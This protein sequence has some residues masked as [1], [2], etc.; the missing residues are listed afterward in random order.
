MVAIDAGTEATTPTFKCIDMFA[1]DTWSAEWQEIDNCLEKNL[2]DGRLALLVGSAVSQYA[3]SSVPMGGEISRACTERLASAIPDKRL[4]NRVRL[5]FNRMPFEVFMARLGELDSRMA[6]DL[7]CRL[8]T[9]CAPNPLHLQLATLMAR[10]LTKAVTL[11]LITTN[12]D[13]GIELAVEQL[14]KQ[15][16]WPSAN[17]PRVILHRED[18]SGPMSPHEI[19][20]IHGMTA[21]PASLVLDYKSEFRLD[22]WKLDHL[23][24]LLQNKVLLVVGFSGM[25]L[26]VSKAVARC[27]IDRVIWIRGD[28][29]ESWTLDAS[30]VMRAARAACAVGVKWRLEQAL[31][32]LACPARVKV[33]K[34]AIDA[35]CEQVFA[36]FEEERWKVWARWAGLRAGHARLAEGL[37]TQEL[38]LL[39]PMHRLE[40]ESFGYY[41]R[42]RHLQG[43]KL[44]RRAAREARASAEE[45]LYYRNTEAEYLNRGAYSFRAILAVFSASCVYWVKWRRKQRA[46]EYNNLRWSLVFA[47]PLFPIWLN[48]GFIQR[49]TRV[50]LDYISRSVQQADLDKYLTI[51]ALMAEPDSPDFAR[52]EAQYQWLGQP[53]RLVNLYRVMAL[54][55]LKRAIRNRD[56]RLLR[57]SYVRALKAI[58]FARRVEDP[59]RLGKCWL[60]LMEVVEAHQ[61]WRGAPTSEPSPFDRWCIFRRRQAQRSLALLRQGEIAGICYWPAALLYRWGLR[62]RGAWHGR[63]RL[64]ALVWLETS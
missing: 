10:A 1:G 3:P 62:G 60:T 53:A 63:L 26:D 46:L 13:S 57:Q 31:D 15:K 48:F 35:R 7:V 23:H 19:F 22:Q 47:W 30:E 49:S 21:D 36:G 6:R 20:H 33:E 56:E 25:D 38:Q 55:C 2:E 32:H 12:Y 64:I 16:L 24:T 5:D 8:T 4:R 61:T 44:Q 34:S 58:R 51:R 40:I 50:F 37:S 43:A 9:T 39:L 28:L 59:C 11:P 45:Y 29:E 52:A 18:S 42:G 14:T 17:P 54:R 27:D 41:Y